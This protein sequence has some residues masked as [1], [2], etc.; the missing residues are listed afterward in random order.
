VAKQ[1]FIS[2]KK[3]VVG[4]LEELVQ[5][6]ESYFDF[7]PKYMAI[8]S[9]LGSLVGIPY[10]EEQLKELPHMQALMIVNREEIIAPARNLLQQAENA[11]TVDELLQIFRQAENGGLS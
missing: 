6:Y 1:D 8:L 11:S 4:L 10:S 3:N 9:Q 5:L 2:I 7:Y